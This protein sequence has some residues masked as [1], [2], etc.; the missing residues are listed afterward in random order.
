MLNSAKLAKYDALARDM[1]RHA[2]QISPKVYG[3]T[4][5]MK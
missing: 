1:E 5:P 4:E 3:K 2:Y